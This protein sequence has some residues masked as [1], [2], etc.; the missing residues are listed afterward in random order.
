[1][2][3]TD[4]HPRMVPAQKRAEETVKHIL[5]TSATLLD[6]VGLDGF[7]TNLLA[8]RS[9][10]RV[11]TI[12]RYFPNKLAILRALILE[13]ANQMK[14]ALG[15][16]N[17]LADPEK[18]WQHIIRSSIDNYVAAAK[19]QK[20]FISIRRAMQA[21][22]ELSAIEKHLVRDLSESIVEAIIKRGANVSKKHLFHVA[23]TFL[24]AAAATYDL[25]Y[26]KGKK[27]HQAEDEIIAEL[28]LMSI[29]YLANYL[30]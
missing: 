23:G 1:V 25:A 26:L 20:G 11:G 4:L 9:G 15:N 30:A 12:Y 22:P 16:F 6:E 10:L 28:K 18:E 2:T 3:D 17:D 21:A 27:N 24:M 29:S 8:D 5:N 14:M 19:K 13:Y 7:N